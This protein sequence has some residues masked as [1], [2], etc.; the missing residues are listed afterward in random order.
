MKII[1]TYF[2]Y[3][4]R[5][6]LL[7]K[8]SSRITIEYNSIKNTHKRSVVKTNVIFTIFLGVMFYL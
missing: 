4:L 5:F 2:L 3:Y 8:F 6:R 7:S 1:H